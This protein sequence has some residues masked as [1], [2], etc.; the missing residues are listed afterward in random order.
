[1]FH[2]AIKTRYQNGR[3]YKKGKRQVKWYGQFREDQIN[4]DGKLI[5]V[6]RNIC[7]GTLAKLP[8][9]QAAKLEL[10]RRMG[11][12][13][14]VTA[15]MLFSDLVLR[16]QTAVVPTLR[17]TTAMHYEYVLQTYVVPVFGQREIR[18][19]TRFDVELFLAGKAK[20][21][22][23]AT[24]RSMKVALSRVLSW[25]VKCEWLEK[26]PLNC[27]KNFGHSLRPYFNV[28][29]SPSKGWGLGEGDGV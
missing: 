13:T 14:P 19:I 4:A 20:A 9:N 18:C 12:E 10:A 1:M 15:D 5:R 21:Y 26:N 3:V 27:D 28:F 16:W 23:R 2:A 25:A 7:L 11:T 24:I 8:T 17:N 29:A 22:C 6:Q